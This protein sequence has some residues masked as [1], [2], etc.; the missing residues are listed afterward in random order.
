MDWKLMDSIRKVAIMKIKILIMF[1]ILIIFTGCGAY[2]DGLN[3]VEIE[4]NHQEGE[5]RDNTEKGTD[6]D[7]QD[8]ITGIEDSTGPEETVGEGESSQD[9][10]S[11]HGSSQDD[12]EITELGDPIQAKI[13][14]M[15]DE[16]TLEDKIAQLFIVD[17]YNM[18]E[19]YQVTEMSN[20]ISAFMERYPVS[21]IIHFSD[22]IETQEQISGFNLALQQASEYPL[23]I[24]VDEEG[25]IVSRL[26]KAN[27]GVDSL[28]SANTLAK[29]YSAKE[30]TEM[31]AVLGRQ[32]K[33]LGFNYDFAPVFDANTNPNNP[34]I[35]NRAFGSEVDTVSTYATAFYQGLEASGV[36]SSAKHFPGHGDTGTDSHLGIASIDHDLSRLINVEL[37]PFVKAIDEGIPTIMVG[38]ITA[39]KVTGTNDPASLSSMMLTDLLRQDLGFEGVIISDS[40]RMQAITDYYGQGDV[41][42]LFIQA[43]GDI[44]LLPENFEAAY[45]GLV[46]AV[47][48]G[49]ITEKRIDES[50]VRI[51]KLKIEYGLIDLDHE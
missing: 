28:A 18:T 33:E 32:M 26:G 50:V 2:G 27:V 19:T 46:D 44:I 42:R 31:A 39:P 51:L 34:V 14:Q 36:I 40:F 13:E 15:L 5:V 43:G 23:F 24:A 17:T 37:V 8:H 22:N 20:S 11:Q 9:D 41:G 47:E 16:M 6:E 30:V 38:H 48:Q 7:E 49:M 29:N 25:G 21:G 45:E 3:V 12:S 4:S 35:G 1:L 10:S